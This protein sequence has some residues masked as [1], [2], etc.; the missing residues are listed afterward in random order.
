MRHRYRNVTEIA[1]LKN[2]VLGEGGPPP[3]GPIWGFVV[4][5][6]FTVVITVD[7]LSDGSLTWPKVDIIGDCSEAEYSTLTAIYEQLGLQLRQIAQ[8]RSRHH[9]SAR[10][11]SQP[12]GSRLEDSS[13]VE[14]RW[15]QLELRVEP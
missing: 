10:S 3:G 11:G 4:L 6:E 5:S 2:R 14:P 1:Q 9:R 15:W 7:R 12:H 8:R 13:N